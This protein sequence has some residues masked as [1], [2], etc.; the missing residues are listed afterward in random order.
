MPINASGNGFSDGYGEF[1]FESRITGPEYGAADVENEFSLRPRTFEEYIGQDAVKENL[2]VFIQAARD[3]GDNL[4][5]VLLHGPPGLGKTTL[6]CIIASALGVNLK[7]TSGPAIE[8]TGDLAALLT[9]LERNDVLFIDEI[10]RLPRAVEEVLYPAMEDFALDFMTGKGPSAR[11]IRIPLQPFTLIG[12]TT[13]AGSLTNPLR[14]RF[15]IIS[16]LQ[17]YST[18]D[19]AHIVRRSAKLLNVAIEDEGA[20]EI[21]RR[22]RGTP[23]IA[24]RLLRRVRDYAQVRHDGLITADIADAALKMLAVDAMGLD[25]VDQKFLLTIMEKFAGGPVGIDNLASALGEDRDTLEDVVEPYLIQQGLVQRTPRGRV[26]CP[27][28]YR[29]FGLV[30]QAPEGV[31]MRDLFAQ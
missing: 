29:H 11:S 2:S 7:V 9:T 16:Q 4:D 3:R 17:F 19:L 26:A 5:H 8:K 25:A 13:R 31:V 24:N 18:T 28:A 10:H 23:R 22:S 15:G 20:L 12:A 1:D 30:Q 6:S 21:A 14:A 27:A